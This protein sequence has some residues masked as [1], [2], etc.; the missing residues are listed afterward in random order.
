MAVAREASPVDGVD[1]LDLIAHELRQPLTAARGSVATIQARRGNPDF[2]AATEHL[3]LE[4]AARNL[5]QLAALLD[6]LRVFS[7]ADRGDLDIVVSSVYMQ[8]LFDD[9]SEDFPQERTRRRLKTKCP[10][11]LVVQVDRTLFK[12]VITN[13]VA[14]AIK[15]SPPGSTVLLTAKAKRGKV[16]IKVENEGAGFPAAEGERIFQKSVRL[17]LGASGLGMGLY[18]A[19]AIV[20]AHHGHVS[21]TSEEGHGAT[22]EVALPA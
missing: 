13:L 20:E 14:N 4:V 5:D 1:F 17:N 16:L 19:R 11:D 10:R 6:S 9:C 8:R 21:A 15:F 12:Q 7:E 2:D 3:L 22:F 18:V